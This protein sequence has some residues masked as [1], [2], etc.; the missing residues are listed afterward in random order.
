MRIIHHP[1][2]ILKS[3]E[4]LRVMF[5]FNVDNTSEKRESMLNYYSRRGANIRITSQ[6]CSCN[7]DVELVAQVLNII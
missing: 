5:V 6:E 2:Q 4:F 1:L 3:L 7:G